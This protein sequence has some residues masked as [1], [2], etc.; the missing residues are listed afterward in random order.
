MRS[1]RRCRALRPAGGGA[2]EFCL[3]TVALGFLFVFFQ[4][5]E[6]KEAYQELGLT[7]GSGIYGSTI[8]MLTGF[9]GMHVTLGAVFSCTFTDR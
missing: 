4:V 9:H 5:E 2:D 6:Y 3:A 1:C 7:L 8:F